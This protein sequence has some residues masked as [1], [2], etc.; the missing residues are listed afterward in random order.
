MASGEDDG[1]AWQRW[2]G[3]ASSPLAA[4]YRP[5]SPEGTVLHRAVREHLATFL[6]EARTNSAHGFGLPGFI[7]REFREY[8][9]CGVLAHGFARLRC[10]SCGDEHLVGFSCKRRGVCPSC[11]TRRAVDAAA[12]LVDAVL[13]HVPM[14]QW[15]L[16]LPIKVRWLLAR[17]PALVGRVLAVFLRALST[18]QRR[19]GR[20]TGVEGAT[21]TATFVQRFGSALQLNIHFHAVVPDGVFV[22]G[23]D[24]AV[25]FSRLPPPTDE[26]VELLLHRTATRV[27]RMLKGALG[28]EEPEVDALAELCAASMAS[29]SKSGAQG[30]TPKQ[31]TAF[32]EGFSLHA[33]VH[34]HAHDR[35]GL[36]QL[37]RYGARGA[38]A[39]SRLSELQDGRYAYRMKRPLPDGRTHL[40]LDGVGLLKKLAPLIPPPRFHLLRFHG[41]FAPNSKLRSLVVPKPPARAVEERSPANSKLRSLVVP[42]PP[43]RAVE[44]RSPAVKPRTHPAPSPYRLDWAA[45]LKRVYGVDVLQCARC[46]GRLVILAFIEKRSAVRAIRLERHRQVPEPLAQARRRW[47]MRRPRR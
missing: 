9:A 28:D 23:D 45:A 35:R 43:A 16:S 5:R 34:L 30:A 13:P 42:K 39:L 40:V 47:A 1:Q 7:E 31:L 24:G 25:S 15:V 4:A 32:L 19:R 12:H 8:L 14:R 41:V 38:L 2:V 36:E 44:E 27:L 22:P 46:C 37:C 17:R 3:A 29:R 18:W 6:E 33:G 26:D 10:A 20:A 11:T 21:G